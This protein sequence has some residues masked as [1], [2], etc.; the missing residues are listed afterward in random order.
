MKKISKIYSLKLLGIYFLCIEP[1]FPGCRKEAPEAQEVNK[2]H[3]VLDVPET[4]K[5]HKPL[6]QGYISGKIS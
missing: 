6:S 1:F 3:K 2:T 4:Y 5:I